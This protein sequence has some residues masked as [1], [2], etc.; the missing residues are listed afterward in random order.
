VTAE[1]VVAGLVLLYAIGAPF[2]GILDYF[3]K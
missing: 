1:D 2:Y 3:L